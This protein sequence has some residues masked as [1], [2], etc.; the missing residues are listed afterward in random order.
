[1]RRHEMRVDGTALYSTLNVFWFLPIKSESDRIL[2]SKK[3]REEK[4]RRR[5]TKRRGKKKNEENR[6]EEER[7]CSKIFSNRDVIHLCS[8]LSAF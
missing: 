3:R 4:K 6:R 5:E 1:M 2:H 8:V 7:E